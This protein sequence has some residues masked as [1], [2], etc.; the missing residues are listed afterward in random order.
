MQFISHIVIIILCSAS[1]YVSLTFL[2]ALVF[3]IFL[4]MAFAVC[5]IF[6]VILGASRMYEFRSSNTVTNKVA[7]AIS[8]W[9]VGAVGGMLFGFPGLLLIY[10]LCVTVL[11]LCPT[12]GLA[13]CCWVLLFFLP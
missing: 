13:F 3:L 8:A 10:C 7:I 6:L 2:T 4:A 5:A 12:L 9:K 11:R 1:P